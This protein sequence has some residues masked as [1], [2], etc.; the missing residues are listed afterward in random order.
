MNDDWNTDGIRMVNAPW[1][2]KLW[3]VVK[4][5]CVKRVIMQ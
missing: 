3:P 1:L 5:I 2:D 4:V